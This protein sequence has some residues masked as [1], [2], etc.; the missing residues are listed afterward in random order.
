MSF[1][2]RTSVSIAW[3]ASIALFASG[4]GGGDASKT[5]TPHASYLEAARSLP[6][7]TGQPLKDPYQPLEIKAVAA[8]ALSRDP[9]PAPGESP[10]TVTGVYVIVEVA[11]TRN[12]FR[13]APDLRFFFKSQSCREK[14]NSC[15]VHGDAHS[16]ATMDE[17]KRDSTALWRAR[18]SG[19]YLTDHQQRYYDAMWT[20]LPPGVS[21]GAVS[22]CSYD[23]V[24]SC[25]SLAGLPDIYKA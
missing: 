8:G 3:V 16:F 13:A 11:A 23:N 9:L 25:F 12:P 2:A 18:P 4:C 6:P 5:P 24:K 17:I 21:A 1:A 7:A 20:Q 10:S 19:E 15:G 14:D 22:L